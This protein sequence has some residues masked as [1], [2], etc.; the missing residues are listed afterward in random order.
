MTMER[1]FWSKTGAITSGG[2]IF[3]GKITLQFT[4]KED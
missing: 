1:E 4:A 3:G 2:K